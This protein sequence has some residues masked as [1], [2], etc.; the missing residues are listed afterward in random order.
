MKP[1]SEMENL[2]EKSFLLTHA[3]MQLTLSRDK[4]HRG[5]CVDPGP[6]SPQAE[7]LDA[8]RPH[9]VDLAEQGGHA[10]EDERREGVHAV[11][12]APHVGLAE[13][14]EHIPEADKGIVSSQR[15]AVN[16][17]RGEIS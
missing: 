3:I 7:L 10:R 11:D 6:P 4:R 1:Q 16:L 14:V 12:N 5:I 2:L 15:V 8:E 9:L 13:A 17:Q